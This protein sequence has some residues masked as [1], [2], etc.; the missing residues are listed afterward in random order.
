MAPRV[1]TVTIALLVAVAY[2]VGCRVG[3][4]LKLLS[5]TPSVVW[6]PNAILAATLLM[7]DP[8]RWV[9]YLLAALPAHLAALL[10]QGLPTAFVWAIFPV[11]CSE[12]LIAALLVRRF[13]SGGR[14]SPH[15]LRHLVV[16]VGRPRSAG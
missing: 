7:S 9:L 12:A 10:P 3:L 15:P 16:V 2:Y 8:R 4:T 1:G 13:A 6:P 5:L 11:N 14:A